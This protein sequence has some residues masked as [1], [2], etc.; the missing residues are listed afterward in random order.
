MVVPEAAWVDVSMELVAVGLFSFR[1]S[2]GSATGIAE[3]EGGA[4]LGIWL[5][6]E[7]VGVAGA[8]AFVAGVAPELDGS[9][10]FGVGG[11]VSFGFI[12]V[13]RYGYSFHISRKCS[14]TKTKY[15]NNSSQIEP[16]ASSAGRCHA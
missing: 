14:H 11:V 12:V 15:P 1:S 3:G 10:V 5:V 9:S 13:S 7:A 8:A 4:M 16:R 6:A 2:V